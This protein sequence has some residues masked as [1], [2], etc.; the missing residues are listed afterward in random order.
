MVGSAVLLSM[1][2]LQVLQVL[3]GAFGAEGVLG[4]MWK[5]TNLSTQLSQTLQCE[6]RGG[7]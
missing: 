1:K 7:R 5:E 4:L 2:V 6:Q 3:Q